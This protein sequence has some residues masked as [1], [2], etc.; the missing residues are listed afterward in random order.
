MKNRDLCI[1]VLEARRSKVEGPTPGKGFL[2][3]SSMVDGR[4]QERGAGRD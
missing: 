4:E 1:T 2:P 3:E